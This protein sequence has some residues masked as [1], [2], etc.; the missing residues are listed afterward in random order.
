MLKKPFKMTLSLKSILI[1][2][3]LFNLSCSKQESPTIETGEVRS[4]REIERLEAC[5]RV[6]FNQG[7]L[8]HQ[9]ALLMFKCTKWDEQFPHMFKAMKTIQR[10]SWDHFIKPIDQAFIENQTR[11]DRF[12]KNIRELDSKNGLD[13]LSYVLVALNETNFFDSTKAMF[14]CV[15]TPGDEIC[16]ERA[17][18]IPQKKSL[19]NVI[20]L[21]DVNSETIGRASRLFKV[22]F[23][24]MGERQ[25]DIR[26]EINKFR[27]NPLYIPLRLKLIDALAY[28]TKTGLNNE[29]RKFISKILLTGSANSQEPW[30]YQWLQSLKMNRQKFRDLI[31]YPILVNPAFVSEFRG[32]KK[33]Y[34]AHFSCTI[35]STSSPNELLSFDFKNYLGQTVSILKKEKMQDYFDIASEGI[36]GLKMSAEICSELEKNKFGVN[37]IS[38]LTHFSEFISE[39]NH[40]DLAR[41]LLTQTPS[42]GDADGTFADNLYLADIV[43]GNIF[44]TFNALNGEITASTREFYPLLFDVLKSLPVDSYVDLGELMESALE[45]ENDPRLIGVAD[46]WN[47]FTDEE[48]NFLFNFLD[49]HFDKETNY[50]LLFDF[51]TKFLDDLQEVQPSLKDSWMGS[52]EKLEMSYLTLQDL[53]TQFSGKDTL[54]DFKKFFSRD[55]ILK[56]LEVISNGQKIN[57]N[58][59]AA[60]KDRYSDDYVRQ[61]RTERYTFKVSYNPGADSNYDAQAILDCM[62]KF[63]DIEL[64]FYEL[65]RKLP[66]ACSKV[67]EENI[68]FRLYGW[69]NT[70]ENSFLDFKKP[71]NPKDS[72]LNDKGVLSPYMLN[73]AIAT[74]KILDS[75]LGS[76]D[77]KV[78]TRNGINYLLNSLQHHIIDKK[79]GP[80]L[81]KNLAL[82]SMYMDILPE[83]NLVLRNSLLRRFSREEV[84]EQTN[85]FVGNVAALSSQYA[86]WVKTGKLKAAQERSLGKYDPANDCEKVINQVVSPNPCPGKEVVKAKIN[87]VIKHLTANWEPGLGTPLSQLLKALKPGEG[88][89]IPHNGKNTRKY[90]MSL[91]ETFKYF[92]DAS[93][94]NLKINN[95][96]M[97]FVNEQGNESFETVTTLERIETVI[98]EVRFGNNYLGVAFLN[99]IVAADDYNKEAK[100][101]RQLLSR[102]IKIPIIRCARPMSKNDLRMARNSLEAFDSLIDINNGYNNEPRLTYGDFLSTFEQTMVASSAKS[103]QV[104]QLFPLKDEVLVQHNGRMLAEMTLMTSWSNVARVIRDRVGRTRQDFE[105]FIDSPEFKRVDRALLYGFELPQTSAS[106]ERL[107]KKLQQVPLGEAEN[108]LSHTVDWAA[109]LNYDQS[110]LVEDTLARIMVVGSYLGSPEVVFENNNSHELASRYKDNNLYQVF[111]S[112]EKLIDYWPVLKNFYPHDTKLIDA[113]KPINTALVFI[114]EKL[115]SSNDPQKNIAYKALNEIFLMLQTTLFDQMDERRPDLNGMKLLLTGLSKPQLVTQTYGVIREDYKLLDNMHADQAAW[116]ASFGLNINR[117]VQARQVDLTPVRDYL[118]FTTKSHVCMTGQTNCP[119]NYHY[120]E[121]FQLIKYLMIKNTAGKSHFSVMT[122]KILSENFDQLNHMLDDLMPALKIKEVRAPLLV[123]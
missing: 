104:I 61:A 62:K 13:D 116:F 108:L 114:T 45:E 20:K 44:S 2:A 27:E 101:R 50:V 67:S 25:E 10:D 111:L 4:A 16:Q 47:F 64:G 52:E 79:A 74:T 119:A 71:N 8:L 3:V 110:R 30:I 120:D 83:E 98:R 6:N 34:D 29:D 96:K 66:A 14:K 56:V 53:F 40:Y 31:E 105:D 94:K 100:S 69:L 70:V 112:L 11:R 99:G 73:S 55:Q 72:L 81:E 109:G 60:L 118:N 7:V 58:A 113:I 86:D 65:V 15:E 49:R 43:T 87:G 18:R 92:Y 88:L 68:A 32:V 1:C 51:Y 54:I 33:A 122:Q 75:L 107:V 48:K 103:A 39:K 26:T 97:K 46:Y 59:K 17:G 121:P 76:I 95:Q 115:T 82:V 117:I 63:S 93:D 37:L 57:S 22:L 38:A 24:V 90:R 35:K 106:A 89:P 23:N 12:F 5:S 84:F 123:Q 78:P 42:R 80:I 77:S 9:N 102:C 36:V 91:R 19:K 41:F 28:K 21:I 85:L